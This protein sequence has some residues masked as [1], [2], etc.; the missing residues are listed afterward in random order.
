MSGNVFPDNFLDQLSKL[1][2]KEIPEPNF[3]LQKCK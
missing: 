3:Y 1:A 2:I